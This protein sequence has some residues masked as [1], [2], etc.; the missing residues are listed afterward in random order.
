MTTKR[1]LFSCGIELILENGKVT[2]PG[3]SN[4]GTPRQEYAD[5]LVIMTDTEL[6]NNC[7]EFTWLSAY[8]TNNKQSDYHWMWDAC[9]LECCRRDRED[10]FKKAGDEVWR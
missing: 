8:A 1:S 3:R 6:F 5:K 4:Y 2:I 7:K 9:I 10:L